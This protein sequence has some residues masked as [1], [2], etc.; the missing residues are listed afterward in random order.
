MTIFGILFSIRSAVVGMKI[1]NTFQH[2]PLLMVCFLTQMNFYEMFKEWVTAF[3][4][5][6]FAQSTDLI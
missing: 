6:V 5:N 4:T 2:M 3:A 1:L